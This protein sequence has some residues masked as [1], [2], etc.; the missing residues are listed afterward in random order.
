ME[1][2]GVGR[3]TDEKADKFPRW[4]FGQRSGIVR[5]KV[6]AALMVK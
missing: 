6:P 1:N 4:H 2:V 5:L 3:G